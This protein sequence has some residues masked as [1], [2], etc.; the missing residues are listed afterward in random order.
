MSST[1]LTEEKNAMRQ[2]GSRIGLVW[3][4]MLLCTFSATAGYASQPLKSLTQEVAQGHVPLG[5]KYFVQYC[6][7]C[8][9]MDASGNGPVAP[10]LRPPPA[11]LRRIA[12]RRG[13]TFPEAEIAAY[14]DGRTFIRAH[15]SREM[16]VWG[17][18]FAEQVGG[19]SVGEE[20]VRG[21]LLLL[22]DYLKSLQ[23]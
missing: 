6:S 18:R 4:M 14:I 12:R 13:G 1:L 21:H 23:Q 16:P 22:V 15:G 20:V 7:A 9:G 5:R 10:A 3:W 11:D 2:P 17:E 19:G 8:H